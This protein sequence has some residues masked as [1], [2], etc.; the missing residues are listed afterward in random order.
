MELVTPNTGQNHQLFLWPL[1]C[2]EA[3]IMFQFQVIRCWGW[4][5]VTGEVRKVTV[6]SFE[7]VRGK[8]EDRAKLGL[9]AI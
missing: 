4:E 3:G 5:L 8:A 2:S 6:G 7:P 9:P 1:S